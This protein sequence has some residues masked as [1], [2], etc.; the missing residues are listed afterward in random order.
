[1]A[2]KTLILGAALAY[3]NQ[4]Y[5]LGLVA[6]KEA[7]KAI[8]KSTN[9]LVKMFEKE[10]KMLTAS[11]L[12]GQ[13]IFNELPENPLI[14]LLPQ[15]VQEQAYS[16][17]AQIRQNIANL[18]TFMMTN[19][20]RLPVDS[21]EFAT[22]NAEI[23]RQNNLLVQYRDEYGDLQQK[24]ADYIDNFNN[25]SESWKLN[26]RGKFEDFNERIFNIKNPNYKTTR[27][28]DGKLVIKTDTDF[29]GEYTIDD[30]KWEEVPSVE[31]N[32]INNYLTRASVY[33]QK[34][35]E[36]PES[37]LYML[38]KYLE[39]NITTQGEL[40]TFMFDPLRLNEK[41]KI[42]LFSEQEILNMFEY[43]EELGYAEAPEDL[44]FEALKTMAIDK[45]IGLVKAE[46]PA[47]IEPS[48]NN[49]RNNSNNRNNRNNNN[50]NNNLNVN[51]FTSGL[52]QDIQLAGPDIV[53]A[54]EFVFN[55]LSTS[56]MVNKLR[57][58]N[59]SLDINSRDEIYNAWDSVNSSGEDANRTVGI[60][61]KEFN[62]L[63]DA[64]KV[65][66]FNE[67]YGNDP[68]GLFIGQNPMIFKDQEDLFRFYLKSIGTKDNVINY[69]ISQI[70]GGGYPG[71]SFG[72]IPDF[73]PQNQGYIYG[74]PNNTV[75]PRDE[76]G[77]I[78]DPGFMLKITN[79]S[80]SIN[81]LP[82]LNEEEFEGGLDPNKF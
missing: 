76:Q 46:A 18:R 48:S 42:P 3:R 32:E 44:D 55:N 49:N 28:E 33:K 1:M 81:N 73:G 62:K 61:K 29:G 68:F 39:D 72:N 15:P 16:E 34:K 9:E 12:L 67:A 58:A 22:L 23:A 30:L 79:W 59:P 6:G 38:R 19:A 70:K 35:L 51:D 7:N 75:P 52:R 54:F 40:D 80:R 78:T 66:L 60:S 63:S 8:Q 37:E 14:P 10:Q 74:D 26:N 47:V 25:I 27:N 53:E 45:I 2:N 17:L 24:T 5:N 77:N 31:L 65:K 71:I 64:D 50:N 82:P 43:N 57:L 69:Y 41:T 56:E 36:I 13:K 4:P 20:A 21:P 11:N